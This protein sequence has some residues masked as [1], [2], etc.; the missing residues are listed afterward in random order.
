MLYNHFTFKKA[1]SD[2]HITILRTA[3]GAEAE[4]R[5][6]PLAFA[7]FKRAETCI[8]PLAV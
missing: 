7:P 3:F 6:L 8:L 4:T 5:I 2:F 1:K